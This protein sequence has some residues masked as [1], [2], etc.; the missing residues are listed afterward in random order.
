MTD[1]P[2]SSTDDQA[3]AA[4]QTLDRVFD[5]A[6]IAVVGASA[7]PIKRGHQIVRALTESGFAG[8]VYPVNPRGGELLGLEVTNSVEE[9]PDGVDL[10]VLCTPAE[11]AP[12]L[13]RACGARG[14]AG[15]VVLAVGFGESGEAGRELESR[16]GKAATETGVRVI[17]PNTSGLLNLERGVNLVGARG[18]RS[19]GMAVLV[20]SGNM[21]LALMTETTERSWDGISIY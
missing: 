5:P 2:A 10:A 20:Q 6:S 12:D 7:D 4:S 19:G 11:A 15:V 8:A 16:L 14:I 9:L 3:R 17:G 21:A 13:V 18:V 1:G